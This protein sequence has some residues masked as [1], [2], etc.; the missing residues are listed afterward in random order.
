MRYVCNISLTPE[1]N[2]LHICF[3]SPEGTATEKYTEPVK[4]ETT[5]VR[6]PWVVYVQYAS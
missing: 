4:V 2:C 3:F 6:Y 1:E 5:E